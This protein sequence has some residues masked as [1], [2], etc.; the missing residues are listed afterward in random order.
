MIRNKYYLDNDPALYAVRDTTRD[1]LWEI[2][3]LKPSMNEKRME[4]FSTL[5]G[6]ME[7]GCFI[8]TPFLCDIGKN[9]YW[10]K[11]SYAAMNCCILDCAPVHIGNGVLIGPNV[12]IYTTNHAIDAQERAEGYVC[13]L[14]VRIE[15][16][17]WIGG[18][19]T[20]L[21][22]V[23][24]GKGS[25]IGAGSVVTKDIPEGVIAVGNPCRVIRKITAE[26]KIQK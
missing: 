13:S 12:S 19:V 14:P 10:G 8:E 22:G 17:V 11:H 7:E 6:G 1:I 25:I 16:N 20:I 4:L 21:S 5:F 18:S 3:N 15:D 23:T 9:I 24:I 26:D 2:N